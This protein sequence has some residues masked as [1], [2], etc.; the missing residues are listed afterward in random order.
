[1]EHEVEAEA[2][3]L[4]EDDTVL[5]FPGLLTVTPANADSDTSMNM[6]ITIHRGACFF[7]RAFL[8]ND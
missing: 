7:I 4:T 2:T 1:L 8:L 3:K 5:P 6:K